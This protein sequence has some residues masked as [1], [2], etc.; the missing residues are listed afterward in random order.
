MSLKKIDTAMK[1]LERYAE[2]HGERLT[3]PR[4][5]VFEIL[6]A[7]TKPMTAYDI[8]DALG[9]KIDKPKPPTV[10]RA[11]E[12]LQKSGFVHRIES[13]NAYVPCVEDHHHKGSQFMICENCGTVEE[14]HICHIPQELKDKASAKGFT[15][16]HWNVEFFGLC[17]Q[18]R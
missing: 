10:Y 8:L 1:A 3:D 18:C 6:V 12:F 16:S 9:Q 11:L 13:L 2:R 17:S 5:F 14:I 15:L 4:R 7:S